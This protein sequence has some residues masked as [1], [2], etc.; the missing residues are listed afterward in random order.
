MVDLPCDYLTIFIIQLNLEVYA[1]WVALGFM[2]SLNL[3]KLY[4]KFCI[5]A[6]L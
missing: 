6:K 5:S 2:E 4:A 1:H 3:L